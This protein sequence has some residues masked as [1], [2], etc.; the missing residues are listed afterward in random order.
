M[1][2]P[3]YAQEIDINENLSNATL[4]L[5]KKEIPKNSDQTDKKDAFILNCMKN[6]DSKNC[7][8]NNV[9]TEK[10]INKNDL[11]FLGQKL[12]MDNYSPLYFNQ[13]PKFLEN[14]VYMNAR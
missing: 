14:S 7:S 6:K 10:M 12:Y 9:S 5:Y 3:S 2:I 1:L 8:V 11:L 4:N 13:Y